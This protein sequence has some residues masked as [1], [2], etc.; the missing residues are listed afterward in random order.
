MKLGWM[1]GWDGR[2]RAFM[3]EGLYVGPLSAW[4]LSEVQVWIALSCGIGPSLV[5][6]VSV[7]TLEMKLSS[8]P[9]GIWVGQIMG[10]GDFRAGKRNWRRR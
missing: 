5:P 9:Y 10:E 8:R 4:K 1:S 3:A 6:R 2:K 7:L